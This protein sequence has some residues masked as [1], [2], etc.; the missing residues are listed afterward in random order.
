MERNLIVVVI[1][2]A[3][4]KGTG[5]DVGAARLEDDLAVAV[6]YVTG[7]VDAAPAMDHLLLATSPKCSFIY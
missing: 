1:L 7:P 5:L 4:W 2:D 3:C 6:R